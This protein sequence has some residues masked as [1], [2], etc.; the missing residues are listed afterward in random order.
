MESKVLFFDIDGTL[1]EG[2]RGIETIPEGALKELRRLQ[3]QGHKL[4]VS[5]GRPKAMIN[6]Y[7]LN[8]GFDGFILANGGYVEIDGKSIFENRMDYDLCVKTTQMLED[9]NCDYMLETAD[10][11]YIDPKFDE[12]YGFFSKVGMK[13]MFQREFDKFDVLKRTIKIEANV[14]D[15]DRKKLEDYLSHKFGS[16]ITHDEHGSENSFE[17]FSPTMSKAIGVQKV[18]EYYNLEQKDT[19][20]FGDGTNDIE[21]IEYCQVGVA[22]GNAVD[23]LKE[24][25]DIICHSIEDNGLEEILKILFR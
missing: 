20:A 6:D 3:A 17:F 13:D 19:Y 10:S 4:F 9:L 8:V 15:K 22:M 12:L 11:I 16:V 5:S 25:A 2:N 7:L 23:A 14:L 21:M 1:L 18:L 24:K